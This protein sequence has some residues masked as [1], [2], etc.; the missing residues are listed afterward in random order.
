MGPEDVI[1]HTLRQLQNNNQP[2]YDSGVEVMSICCCVASRHAAMDNAVTPA[3]SKLHNR[4]FRHAL[5]SA[6]HC[7]M[8]PVVHSRLPSTRMRVS[9]HNCASTFD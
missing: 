3:V 1:S 5:L 7:C 9:G 6:L 2:F 4:C 8:L